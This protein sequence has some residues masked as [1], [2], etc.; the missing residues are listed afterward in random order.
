MDVILRNDDEGAAASYLG[1]REKWREKKLFNFEYFEEKTSFKKRFFQT[2]MKK[3]MSNNEKTIYCYS[4]HWKD[5]QSGLLKNHLAFILLG[6]LLFSNCS[7]NSGGNIW[8]LDCKEGT[9]ESCGYV[10]QEGEV[11][12]DH[13]KYAMSFTDTF[14]HYAI[15]VKQD[16]GIVAINKAEEVLYKV[17]MY[18][19]GPDYPSEGYFRIIEDQKIGYADARTGEIKIAPTYTAARPF[20]HDYAPVCPDCESIKDAGHSKWD[21]GKWGLIDKSGQVAVEAAYDEIR[22]ISAEGK[23][24]VVLEGEEKWIAI[25]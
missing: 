4:N 3:E 10:N 25:Q 20:V 17:F 7:D 18:D 1:V 21:N 19:N 5:N 16:E 11:M 15:V 14:D 8:V 6:L 12:I 23:A 22:E 24:L 2:T 9:T 13:G